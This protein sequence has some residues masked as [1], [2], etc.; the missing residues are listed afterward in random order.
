ML[1]HDKHGRVS[2]GRLDYAIQLLIVLSLVAF[3][4]ETLPNLDASQRS[5][6][7]AFEVFSVIVFTIEYLLRIVLSK[8]SKSYAFSFFGLI[9]LVAILPFYISSGIDLR[10]VRAFRLLRLFRLLKLARY[11]EAMTRFHRA[12]TII[13]EEL[14]LFGAT[15]LII[16]YLASVGIYHFEH[17]A[18]PD[19]F[20]S[21][22]HSFWWAV[23]TLTTVGYGDIY[24]ITLG[25]KIFT[26][27][28]LMVG[29]GFVAIPT[30]LFASALSKARDELKAEKE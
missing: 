29:L 9:D 7:R 22:F 24:P 4:L 17:I 13:R 15:A 6:L 3:A 25:G 26:F 10:S 21:V 19:I 28:I 18:Q 11:S 30:G 5:A 23:A 2:F 27:A 1:Q 12:F 20:T 8:P 16:L 14:I